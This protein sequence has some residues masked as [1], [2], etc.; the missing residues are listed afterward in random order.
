MSWAKIKNFVLQYE[1]CEIKV[2]DATNKDQ[3][4]PS[5]TLLAEISKYTYDS[6]ECD[7]VLATIWDRLG[8]EHWKIV[9]KTLLVIEHLLKNGSKR[10]V[11]EIRRNKFAIKQLASFKYFENRKDQGI[12]VRE[13]SKKLLP[14]ISDLNVLK[15]ERITARKNKNK[16]I[17]FSSDDIHKFQNLSHSTKPRKKAHIKREEYPKSDSE[18]EQEQESESESEQEQEQ[19]SQSQS[20]SQSEPEQEP[21][22]IHIK[23]K[24]FPIKNKFKIIV[25]RAK[26]DPPKKERTNKKKETIQ[27]PKKITTTK[28]TKPEKSLIDFEFNSNE[29]TM[30]N[31]ELNENEN[32][33]QNQNQFPD[34][35]PIEFPDPNQIQF[36]NDPN[37]IQFPNQNPNQ[38]QFPNQNPNQIQFPIQNP[39]QNPNQIQFPNDPNQNDTGFTE[40]VSYPTEPTILSPQK[41]VNL[42]DV[43]F[44]EM[45]EFPNIQSNSNQLK[46]KKAVKNQKETKSQEKKTLWTGIDDFVDLSLGTNKPKKVTP[47]KGK[48]R[49]KIGI[50]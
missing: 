42:Q 35:N 23:K 38:I 32:Q 49:G 44:P 6:T 47:S 12:N 20:Q 3:S 22:H 18:S 24:E 39:N 7:Q 41:P 43:A 46:S 16:Y 10:A 17:G 27:K 8:E 11:D 29:K 48:I 15:K 21:K 50:K 1:E 26:A 19:E 31:E 28:K 40:F 4:G 2:R 36:P 30:E 45:N 34:G 14:L 9:Y 25:N 37:Q 13:K 5:S 33:N